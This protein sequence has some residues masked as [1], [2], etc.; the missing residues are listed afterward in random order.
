VPK[1]DKGKEVTEAPE[2]EINP[3]LKSQISKFVANIQ[4]NNLMHVDEEL[5]NQLDVPVV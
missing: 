2:M 5:S 1:P 3:E 4:N